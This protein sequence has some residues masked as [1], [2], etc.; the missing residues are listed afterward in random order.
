MKIKSAV[1]NA[2]GVLVIQR[3]FGSFANYLWKIVNE[4][5]ED[6]HRGGTERIPI[7]SPDNSRIISTPVS[8]ALSKDLKSRGMSF[9]GTTIAYA[10]MQAVGLVND[11][12][13]ECFRRNVKM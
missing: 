6:E 9:C 11:H 7:S 2:K 10:Y 12:E 1:A 4:Y 13:L 8:D 5:R 3:E